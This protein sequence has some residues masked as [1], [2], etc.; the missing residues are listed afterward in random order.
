MSPGD[1]SPENVY[2]GPRA[3]VLF[4]L[5]PITVLVLLPL[6]PGLDHRTMGW[7]WASLGT[8]VVVYGTGPVI[9]TLRSRVETLNPGK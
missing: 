8:A 2:S 3:R 6:W 4:M 7:S 5:Q 9:R 1:L